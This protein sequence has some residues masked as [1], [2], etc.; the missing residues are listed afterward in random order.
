MRDTP[1]NPHG[2]NWQWAHVRAVSQN[3]R[4][5]MNYQFRLGMNPCWPPS[6]YQ[7]RN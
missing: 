4:M 5:R 3:D 2:L 1:L 7:P 6:N